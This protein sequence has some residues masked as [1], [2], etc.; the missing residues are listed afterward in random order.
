MSRFDLVIFDCDGVLVDSELIVNRVFADHLNELGA[1]VT[2]EYMFEHFV[3]YSMEHCMGLVRDLL[4]SEPPPDF[5]ATH[6]ERTRAA[7]SEGLSPVPGVAELLDALTIPYCVAS[8]GDHAKM[9]TTL[10]ITG[11]LPRFEGRLF[12]VTEVQRGK[13]FPDVFLHA[14]R[15]MGARPERTAV[16]EDTPVGARAGAAAGMTV[17][18]YA[19]RTP[20]DRLRAA[21]AVVFTDMAELP[22]LLE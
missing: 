13:P 3:G 20:P 22:R 5:E 21:G 17:F 1:N 18:G 2:L 12:S 7:L 8:S 11:L 15:A 19:A 16:V 10:G 6:R 9:R 14:A 4:G